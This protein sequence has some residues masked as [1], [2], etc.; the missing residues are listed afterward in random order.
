MAPKSDKAQRFPLK[1][2]FAKS[3][4]AKPTGPERMLWSLL[5]AGRLAH[6]QFRR[7]QPIGPYVVDF[8]CASAKLVIELDGSQH[9]ADEA[10]I[11]DATRTRFLETQGYRVLRFWNVDFMKDPDAALDAIW[12]VAKGIC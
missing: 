7:Q 1:R 8:F 11:A 6:L 12:R 10:V 3:L 2:A 4:R 9:G 5:R